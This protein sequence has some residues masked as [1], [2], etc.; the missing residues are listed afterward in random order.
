MKQPLSIDELLR[1]SWLLVVAL[2][3][4]DVAEEGEA[5]YQRG[6][7]LVE[8]TRQRL[9]GQGIASEDSDH[10]A[11][12]QCVLLDET[13]LNR[14]LNDN[15]YAFW[16]RTP[17]QARF[18]NTLQGG[19]LLYQRMRQVLAQ[20]APNPLVLSCFHRVLMLGF[21]GRYRNQPQQERQA[22][23]AE[24]DA[25]VPPFDVAE[26]TPIL[27]HVGRRS[28]GLWRGRSLWFWAASAVVIVA[29]V[30]FGLHYQLQQSLNDWLQESQG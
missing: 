8:Q 7:E 16:M 26:E 5:L 10:I 30:W 28:T 24:L 27:V 22:L 4:G 15:G 23:I 29:V 18:F 3:N 12:A 21:Q 11:Y 19:E 2:R 20:P 1:D 17:L 13:V 6:V 9:A 25:R 14:P